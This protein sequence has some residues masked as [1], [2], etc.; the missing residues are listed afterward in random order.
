M[1]YL[2]RYVDINLVG[3]A[4][5][6]WS[7]RTYMDVEL[8]K[9]RIIKHTSKGV[10]IRCGPNKK[11]FVLSSARKRYAWPTRREALISFKARK[12]RQIEILHA[13]LDRAKE[14]LCIANE[15]SRS[16]IP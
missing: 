11:K 7:T 15:R 13:Q 14:A 9:Y 1:S 2:Y 12:R 4:A 5:D 8:R 16:P 10:W 3:V 6:A